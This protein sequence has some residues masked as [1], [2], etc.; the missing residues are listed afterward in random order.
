MPLS[1][2]QIREH[3]EQEWSEKSTR[4]STPEDLRYSSPVEDRLLYPAYVDLLRAHGVGV[5][6]RDVLDVGCGSGRWIAFFARKFIPAPASIT[7][8]DYTLASVDL[9]R[10]WWGESTDRGTPLSFRH[11]SI[12]EPGLD[13]GRKFDLINIANV[14]FHIPEPEGFAAALANL[15]RHLKPGGRIVTTEYLPRQSMRTQWMLVRSRY[16]FTGLCLEAGLQVDAVRAFAYFCNDPMGIDGPDDGA[17]AEFYK[18]RA[19]AQ[20]LL[21]SAQGP[22]KEYLVEML[23]DIERAALAFSRERLAEI[24]LPSQKLVML[25]AI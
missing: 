9:L 2:T 5:G 14:L 15:R 3:Y 8:I 11:A 6:G 12:T 25:S 7:G 13:L 18:V 21:A 4:A 23:A 17:R 16:E 19:R 1:Q 20:Q 22:T 10:K 24:D